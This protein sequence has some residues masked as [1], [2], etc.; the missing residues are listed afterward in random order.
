MTDLNK[1]IA[2]LIWEAQE[3]SMEAKETGD[4]E[5]RQDLYY[6]KSDRI[7]KA[8]RLIQK[9]KSDKFRFSIV[10]K[11]D[12]N[13]YDSC[14]VYFATNIEGERLQVSFHGFDNYLWKMKETSKPTRWIRRKSSGQS[15][16]EIARFYDV[17]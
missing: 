14:I 7:A 17:F 1:I 16:Y 2:A 6:K 11:P 15:A 8:I 10:N 5:E 3:A 9:S 4:Y 12:Q 13:G